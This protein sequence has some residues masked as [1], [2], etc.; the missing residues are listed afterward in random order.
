MKVKSVVSCGLVLALTGAVGYGVA[1][2]GEKKDM[3]SKTAA[4]SVVTNDNGSVSRTFV[5]SSI[6]TNGNLVTEHRRETRTNMDMDGNVLQTTTSEYAQ[7]Y[8]V[9]DTGWKLPTAREDSK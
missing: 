2:A 3:T 5:E 9:G 4:S 6:T 8:S 1:N 7:S